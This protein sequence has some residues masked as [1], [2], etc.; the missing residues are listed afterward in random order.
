MKMHIV[1]YRIK[2]TQTD[3]D[4]PFGFCCTAENPDQAEEQFGEAV[5]DGD[6]VWVYEV[7]PG[8]GRLGA[9]PAAIRD[10]WGTYA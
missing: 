9:Y 10:Y 2:A 1:L 6:V 5:P 7:P 3:T 4:N 8:M